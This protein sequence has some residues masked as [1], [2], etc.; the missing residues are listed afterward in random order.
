M[1]RSVIAAYVFG[2]LSDLINVLHVA[3]ID[4]FVAQKLFCRF[5]A[6]FGANGIDYFRPFRFERFRREPG[7]AFAVGH[8]HDQNRFV[9]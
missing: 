9:F 7:D 8:T 1:D 4:R 2:E 5:L 6:R 3:H